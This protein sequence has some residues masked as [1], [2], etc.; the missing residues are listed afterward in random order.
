MFTNLVHP[1][2]IITISNAGGDICSVSFFSNDDGSAEVLALIDTSDMAAAYSE[3][4]SMAARAI[5]DSN[6]KDLPSVDGSE[7]MPF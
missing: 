3:L 6:W 4:L 5:T 7:A 2:V 1:D